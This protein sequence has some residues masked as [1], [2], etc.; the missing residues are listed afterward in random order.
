MQQSNDRFAAVDLHREDS[1][2]RTYSTAN[3]FAI[4]CALNEIQA[5]AI[6]P[7]PPPE[8]TSHDRELAQQLYDEELARQLQDKEMG[9]PC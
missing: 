5:S 2:A 4:A 6:E 7:T 1:Y 3:D 9:K 8:D